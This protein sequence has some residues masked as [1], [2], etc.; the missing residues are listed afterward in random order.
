[1]LEGLDDIP[2][3]EL[4]HAYGSAEN[5]PGLLRD[6]HPDN[7]TGSPL[8]Y[9][10]GNIYHQG[11]LYDS[12]A[13]AV[14]FLIE[15]AADTRTRERVGILQLLSFIAASGSYIK[16]SGDSNDEALDD[17]AKDAL[18][19]YIAVA[20]GIEPL[21]AIT[22]EDG[23]IALAA[24]Y[25]L[26]WLR[27][28]AAVLAPVVHGLLERETESVRRAGLLLLLAN[29]RDRSEPTLDALAAGL[30]T[31]EVPI[32]RAAAVLAATLKLEPQLPGTIDAIVDTI[33]AGGAGG[34]FAGLPWEVDIDLANLS[35]ALDP[36][37][38]LVTA[39]RI[40]AAIE[41]PGGE[42]RALDLLWIVSWL[43]KAL[44]PP[45]KRAFYDPADFSP[46]QSHAV[47]ALAALAERGGLQISPDFEHYGLPNLRRGWR[48]LL[49]GRKPQPID[50]TLPILATPDNPRE[51]I[52][53][54][55]VVVGQRIIHQVFGLGTVTR[56]EDEEGRRY[57]TFLFDYEGEM[58]LGL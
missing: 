10:F 55:D 28:H 26:S 58:E 56:I 8:L 23:D 35:A 41:S 34:A 29:L 30:M 16:V 1:M 15:L 17:E 24:A 49:A 12:T 7:N 52:T 27:D 20:Q 44:F 14:P 18:Q 45:L 53:S 48:D 31:D 9:L 51:S 11:T 32:R 42:V 25:T 46:L 57:I 4:S 13:Y 50:R 36:A 47:R 37:A 3:S 33:A 21:I 40:I 43:L 38:R 2:W 6:L 19:A 22:D 5:V 54:K 39:E